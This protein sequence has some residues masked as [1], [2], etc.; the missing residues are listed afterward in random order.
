MKLFENENFAILSLDGK[1][2]LQNFSLK[3]TIHQVNDVITKIPRVK[4]TEFS[5]L[6]EAVLLA[7]G[8]ERVI[9]ILK[10]VYEIIVSNDSM[11]A[12][13][14]L[15][16]NEKDFEEKGTEIIR[17]LSHALKE[18]NITTGIIDEAL[19]LE[20][21]R[22]NKKTLIAEGILPEKGENAKISYY[23]IASKKP[24]LDDKNNANHYEMNLINNIK[25]GDWLGEKTA[26]TKGKNGEN[27]Y[28]EVLPGNLGEDRQLKYDYKSIDCIEKN[29]M[30]TLVVKKHFILI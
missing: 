4:L 15:N 12:Y 6:K 9:G 26:A 1:I 21:I 8:K 13:Y 16:M 18:E 27:V 11:K 30:E 22:L 24:T 23:K 14:L 3:T 7:D 5:N 25:K 10:E 19:K 17:G 20:N 29:N 28:G 2:I